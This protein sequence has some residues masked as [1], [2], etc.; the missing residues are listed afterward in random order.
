MI[1]ESQMKTYFKYALCIIRNDRLLVLDPHVGDIVLISG[2]CQPQ[3]TR[4]AIA[5]GRLGRKSHWNI[6]GVL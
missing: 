2:V 6:L 3:R 4:G 1:L 5:K